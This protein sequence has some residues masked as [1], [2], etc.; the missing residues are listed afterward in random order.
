MA[1]GRVSRLNA[2]C[3]KDAT[4]EVLSRGKVASDPKALFEVLREHCPCP[5][6]IVLETGTL[7]FW[8]ARGL[9]EL[10][11]PVDAIDA[12]PERTR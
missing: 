11:L 3:V 1:E 12:R 8:L 2:F 7:S 9:R 5:K 6:R 4:G 10:G